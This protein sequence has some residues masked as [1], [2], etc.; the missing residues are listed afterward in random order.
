[1]LNKFIAA[2]KKNKELS[3]MLQNIEMN[4]LSEKYTVKH[5]CVCVCVCVPFTLTATA[6][7]TAIC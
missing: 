6:A 1:V 2:W 4:M 3:L 7:S 5:V